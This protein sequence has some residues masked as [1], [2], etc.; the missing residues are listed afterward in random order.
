MISRKRDRQLGN[1]SLFT[2]GLEEA[3]GRG[4]EVR[5]VSAKRRVGVRLG[6]ICST[7]GRR[8]GE[9]LILM[10]DMLLSL[11]QGW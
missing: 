4:V 11:E 5:R 9:D 3:A 7:N 6:A 8:A 2:V 10:T 1:H